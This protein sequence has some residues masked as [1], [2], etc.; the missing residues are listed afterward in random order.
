MVL[1]QEHCK[2]RFERHL[3]PSINLHSVKQYSAQFKPFSSGSERNPAIQFSNEC[4]FVN[5]PT[6]EVGQKLSATLSFFCKSGTSEQPRFVLCKAYICNFRY[7]ILY[8]DL[9][10]CFE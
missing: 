3:M 1:F 5:Q 7:K 4:S 9:D 10:L 8:W 2:Q 6:A